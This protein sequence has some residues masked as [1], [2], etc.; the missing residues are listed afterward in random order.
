MI[1]A[2]GM[3][4]LITRVRESQSV[5]VSFSLLDGP[6]SQFQVDWIRT[7]LCAVPTSYIFSGY[8]YRRKILLLLNN[9]PRIISIR[10]VIEYNSTTCLLLDTINVRVRTLGLVSVVCVGA[11]GGNINYGGG[12]RGYLHPRQI[13][14]DNWDTFHTQSAATSHCSVL[15]PSAQTN[16][17]YCFYSR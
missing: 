6:C 4:A 5:H 16:T 13:T 17:K 9:C 2:S 7:M 15:A 12:R 8:N 11:G 10:Y 1:P 3:T 14:T